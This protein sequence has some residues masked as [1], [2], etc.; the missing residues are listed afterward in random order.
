[1]STDIP[2]PTYAKE[3]IE[4]AIGGSE[5][6]T[7]MIRTSI[8]DEGALPPADMF[9]WYVGDVGYRASIERHRR[10]HGADNREQLMETEME[11]KAV[12]M[13][14]DKT[15]QFGLSAKLVDIL[16]VAELGYG[17]MLITA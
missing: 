16:R 7:A 4:S 10:S 9:A 2:A 12:Q 11:L 8:F 13:I 5:L 15:K 6:L 14:L 3:A 1:V 17:K